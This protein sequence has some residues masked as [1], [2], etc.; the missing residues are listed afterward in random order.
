M[1]LIP[2]EI[3]CYIN[4]HGLALV[5]VELHSALLVVTSR[6]GA[7]SNKVKMRQQDGSWRVKNWAKSKIMK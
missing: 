7:G 3:L 4:L 1:I 6:L 2:T 5:V